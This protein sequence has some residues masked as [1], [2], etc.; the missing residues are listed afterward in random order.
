MRRRLLCLLLLVACHR[1]SPT[2]NQSVTSATV[3]EDVNAATRDV[4]TD[5][6][7][8]RGVAHGASFAYRGIP[9]AAP[10]HRFSPPEPA[11]RW[12]GAREARDFGACCTQMSNDRVEGSE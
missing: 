9:C 3:P 2:S 6:G 12:S 11:T 7:V 1:R 5:L 4:T 8:V 10:P